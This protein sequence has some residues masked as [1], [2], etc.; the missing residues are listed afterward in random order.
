LSAALPKETEFMDRVTMNDGKHCPACSQDIGL[1]SVLTAGSPSRVRC[2][3][4]KHRLVY[5]NSGALVASLLVLLLA[6][7]AVAFYF[8]RQVYSA[9]RLPFHLWL[10]GVVLAAWLP[11]ELAA[12]VYLRR[13]GVLKKA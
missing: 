10:A 1:W 7:G 2:P 3:H 11:V 9:N 13:R 8:V 6:L 4:C 5:A 12:A